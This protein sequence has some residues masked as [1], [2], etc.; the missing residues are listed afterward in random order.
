MLIN[1]NVIRPC[2]QEGR[3]FVKDLALLDANGRR[4]CKDCRRRIEIRAGEVRH[5]LLSGLEKRAQARLPERG[6]TALKGA[7]R[8]DGSAAK[9]RLQETLA[10]IQS[11][12][13][14]TFETLEADLEAAFNFV[15]HECQPDE[16]EEWKRDLKAQA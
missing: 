2:I 6:L 3:P 12:K 10:T 1:P 9:V 4:F 16:L 5:G 11:L 15:A 13:D 8:R 14:R 7:V